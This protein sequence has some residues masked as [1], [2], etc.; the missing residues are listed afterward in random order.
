MTTRLLRLSELDTIDVAGVHWLP[1]RRTLG[2]T[3][4]GVNAYRARAGE[5]VVEAHDETGTGAGHHEELYVVV[6]GRARFT[7]DGEEHDA[8]TGTLVFVPEAETR[9]EAVAVEDGT[10][11]L[12][13]GGRAGSGLPVSP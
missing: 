4:F 8:P 5:H 12:A 7:L 3:G 6:A 13:V 1:L 10:T 11:V 2:V 9:R